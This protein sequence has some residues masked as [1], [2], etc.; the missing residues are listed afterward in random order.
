MNMNPIKKGIEP[1]SLPVFKTVTN[2]TVVPKG[3]Q[4][5]A[6]VAS[7][8]DPARLAASV[9][10]PA[11]KAS[12]AAPASTPSRTDAPKTQSKPKGESPTPGSSKAAERRNAHTGHASVAPAGRERGG[13]GAGG[14]HRNGHPDM[15]DWMPF[16]AQQSRIA[17]MHRTY[18]AAGLAGQVK[19]LQHPILP[20]KAAVF[21]LVRRIYS[22]FMPALIRRTPQER[23]RKNRE[24]RKVA[25]RKHQ[26]EKQVAEKQQAQK[27]MRNEMRREAIRKRAESEPH[28]VMAGDLT[29]VFSMR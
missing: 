16:S 2:P 21:S 22:E 17:R 28:R 13:G 29:T 12:E 25:L 26:A 4:P 18:P 14:F 19:V 1:S 15:Q 24:L 11:R 5:G 23:A 9:N 10:N 3:G 7:T 20:L 8:Q 6:S 27:S